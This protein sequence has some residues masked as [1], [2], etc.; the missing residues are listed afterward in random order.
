TA[1]WSVSLRAGLGGSD[2]FATPRSDQHTSAGEC[3]HGYT[4]YRWY[5]TNYTWF[6]KWQY[7][8][9][10]KRLIQLNETK[11]AS[12]GW[13]SPQYVYSCRWSA[14]VRR[15]RWLPLYMSHKIL[16]LKLLALGSR[17]FS[18]VCE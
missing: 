8:Q 13:R 4:G 12:D 18:T 15:N 3:R 10:R 17:S 9:L 1:V 2:D 6:S 5:H 14:T 16:V 11:A 7:V